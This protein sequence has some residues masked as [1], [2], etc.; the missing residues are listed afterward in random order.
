MLDMRYESSSACP[1]PLTR[2]SKNEGLLRGLKATNY[3]TRVALELRC[4]L[5]AVLP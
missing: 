3:E 1:K 2:C 4:H 5:G